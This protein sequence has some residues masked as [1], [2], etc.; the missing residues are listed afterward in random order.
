MNTLIA[1]F[2]EALVITV[3]KCTHTQ[4]LPICL[5]LLFATVFQLHHGSGMMYEVRRRKADP[6]LLPTQGIFNLLHPIGMGMRGT[7][8]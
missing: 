1:C 7:D 5:L 4:I 6:T 3:R 8:L 2:D